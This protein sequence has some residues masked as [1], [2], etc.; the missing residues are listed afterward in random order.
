MCTVPAECHERS[1]ELLYTVWGQALYVCGHMR[2]SFIHFRKGWLTDYML[3]Q[4]TSEKKSL[5]YMC[6]DSSKYR[7]QAFSIS[8]SNTKI[9]Y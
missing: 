8:I 7:L 6:P 4:K 3:Q 5:L 2:S 1:R 9:I